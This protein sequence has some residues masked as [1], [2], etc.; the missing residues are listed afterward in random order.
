M[1]QPEGAIAQDCVPVAQEERGEVVRVTL[2]GSDESVVVCIIPQ[3]GHLHPASDCV[4]LKQRH[5][6]VPA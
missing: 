1:V 2:G 5:D 6:T 4:A 3:R